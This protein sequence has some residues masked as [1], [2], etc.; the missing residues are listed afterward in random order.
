ML[1]EDVPGE[2]CNFLGDGRHLRGL[3]F[4]VVV[5]SRRLSRNGG[6]KVMRSSYG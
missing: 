3:W 5:M 1:F 6:L 2:T 4:V